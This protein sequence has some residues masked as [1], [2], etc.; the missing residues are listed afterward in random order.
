MTMSSG[1]KIA[2]TSYS[3]N[4]THEHTS[5]GEGTAHNNLQPYIV[6][7]YIIKYAS[8]V[9]EHQANIDFYYPVGSYYK[10]SNANFN[11]NTIWGGTWVS[12]NIIDNYIV[13]EG[14]SGI[15]T[16]R[17]WSSGVSECWGIKTGSAT[18]NTTWGSVYEGSLGSETYPE[19]L[20]IS[21]P[22][23]TTS[24]VHKGLASWVE[25]GS[26]SSATSTGALYMVRPSANT[27]NYPYGISIRAVGTWKTYAAPNTQYI[28]HRTA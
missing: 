18:V 3:V 7:N 22:T 25:M 21:Q 8:T 10:T 4:A 17:K 19:N 28:W 11:P 14:T 26:G 20:F 12:E 13:E 5:V 16:Y 15:W 6:T 1:D 24:S 2:H 9:S 23:V 27:S